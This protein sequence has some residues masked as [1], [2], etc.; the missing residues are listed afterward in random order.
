M[1][2]THFGTGDDGEF[3]RT[4]CGRLASS[5]S[6]VEDWADV[7]CLVCLT[8]HEKRKKEAEKKKAYFEEQASLRARTTRE[9]VDVELVKCVC[10]ELRTKAR[11][12]EVRDGKVVGRFTRGER[13]PACKDKF[14]PITPID[15]GVLAVWD[16]R[17]GLR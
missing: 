6:I 9:E 13:C 1:K 2:K 8:E 12:H 15:S 16:E 5:V 10:G 17:E 3:E 4:A 14:N 7:T 11:I